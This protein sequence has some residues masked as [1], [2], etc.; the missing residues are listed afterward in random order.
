MVFQWIVTSQVTNELCNMAC[1][2]QMQSL[3]SKS[4]MPVLGNQKR[5]EKEG[6]NSS[7]DGWPINLQRTWFRG[8]FVRREKYKCIKRNKQVYFSWN[9]Q[10]GI[11]RKLGQWECLMIATYLWCVSLVVLK[12]LWCI[13]LCPG[14]WLVR[15]SLHPIIEKENI[16][17][18][19]EVGSYDLNCI[20]YL[21]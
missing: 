3:D 4:P 12:V 19:Y 1:S 14:E 20:T 16:H 18:V 21:H 6:L 13:F 15:R 9:N 7:C 10:S 2:K 8:W 17:S 5:K 11:G